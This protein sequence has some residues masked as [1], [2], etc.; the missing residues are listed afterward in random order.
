MKVLFF[1]KLKDITGTHIS[2][3]KGITTLSM[4]KEKLFNEYP[5]LE[6]EV[7]VFSVNQEIVSKDE[8]RELNEEDEVALLPPFAGG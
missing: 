2:E 7:F 4:L 5:E 6:G 1:G 3:V 8:D